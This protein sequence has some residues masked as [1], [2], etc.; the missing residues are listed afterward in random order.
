MAFRSNYSVGFNPA[1][2]GHGNGHGNRGGQSLSSSMSSLSNSMTSRNGYAGRGSQASSNISKTYRQASTLF[3]TR[4]LPEALT[5]L[6]PLISPPS[7]DDDDNHSNASGSYSNKTNGANG[8]NGTNGTNGATSAVVIEPAP[9]ASAS[10]ATRVKV[11]SLYLTILNAIVEL[12]PDEGKSAFGTQD[13]R[14]LC[15]KV[16]DGEVWEEVVRNGYH[17]AEGDVDADVV[18]NLATLLLAHAKTQVLNQ[19]RLESYLSF[20]QSQVSPNLDLSGRF[21]SLQR[22]SLSRHRSPA[23]RTP[24]TDTPRD[25]NSR[26]KILELYT[27]HVLRRNDEWDYAR[28]FITAS[29]ILDEERREAFL[30]ALQSLQDEQ[31]EAEKRETEEKRR[32]E[33]LVQQELEEQRRIRA[34]NEERERRR[35]EEERARRETGGGGGAGDYSGRGSEVEYSGDGMSS[36]SQPRRHKAPSSTAGSTSTRGGGRTRSSKSAKAASAAASLSSQQPPA[37]ASGSSKPTRTSAAAKAK[38]N[39]KSRAVAAP[40]TLSSRTAM[41]FTNL[42]GFLE[43]LGLAFQTTPMALLRTLI[44]IAALLIMLGRQAN[45]ERISRI[46]SG[47]WNKVKATAGM[48]VKVSYI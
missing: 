48:S 46:L 33:E 4:R 45:R 31:H 9:V 14:A 13:W 7:V 21:D 40:P 16:R 10:R 44:F 26:V 27:L 24:G 34:E 19:K 35:I 8:A 11:W 15:T 41:L 6:L 37:S 18:I 38:A 43:Q 20:S 28:E 23:R 29:P 42:R 39:K 22:R 32:Q 25:L 3:L 47:V 17:G 5:T 12:E 2:A 36:A 1:F 30:L